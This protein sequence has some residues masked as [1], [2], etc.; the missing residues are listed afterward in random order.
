MRIAAFIGWL[1][2]CILGGQAAEPAFRSLAPGGRHLVVGFASGEIPKLPFNLALLKRAQLVGVDWGG[3]ARA[4]PAINQE[5]M[6][7]LMDW[8]V[9]GKLQPAQIISRQMQDVRQALTDQ[10]AGKIIGKLVLTN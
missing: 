6:R 1:T 8:V 4:N 5:L 3:E 2:L 7:T 10:L 9:S